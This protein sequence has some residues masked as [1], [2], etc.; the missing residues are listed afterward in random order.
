MSKTTKSSTRKTVLIV[1][2]CLLAIG[3]AV[4]EWYPRGDTM[5]NTAPP[6]PVAKAWYTTDDGQTWFADDDNRVFPFD[7]A[8]K[9]AYRCYVWTCDGGKTE[10]VSHLE[11]IRDPLWTQRQATGR[12]TPTDLIIMPPLDVKL[13]KTGEKGWI[14]SSLPT[15]VQIRTPRCPDGRTPQLVQPH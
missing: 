2:G 5:R 15:A 12:V 8:G 13:P 4:F 9:K 10:F 3:V 14:D 11:R 7:K 1:V 6:V